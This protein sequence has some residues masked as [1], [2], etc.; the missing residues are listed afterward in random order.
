MRGD[1]QDFDI[2]PTDVS[3]DSDD[4][5]EGHYD[6]GAEIQQKIIT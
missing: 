2:L 3:E 1:T 6:Y 5:D 4:A